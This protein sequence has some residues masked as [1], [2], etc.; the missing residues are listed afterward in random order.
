MVSGRRRPSCAFCRVQANGRLIPR[1]F[2]AHTSAT[3]RSYC[4]TNR[5]ARGIV[6]ENR[7]GVFAPLAMPVTPP[8][9][10][11]VPMTP[12]P[13]VRFCP[14]TPAPV[15]LTLVPVTPTPWAL[16]PMTPGPAVRFSPTTP[17]PVELTVVPFTP[18]RSP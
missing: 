10:A 7:Y 3:P 8:P 16:V 5:V 18:V 9:W 2:E 12:G 15:E 1:R 13:V 17:A 14:T 6:A 11:L 4:D